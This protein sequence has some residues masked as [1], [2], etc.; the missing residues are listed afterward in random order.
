MSKLGPFERH[1]FPATQPEPQ[2]LVTVHGFTL[3]LPANGP[4][5]ARIDV[6]D[7]EGVRR[8]VEIVAPTGGRNR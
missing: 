5:R 2:T 4:I 1:P 3:D 7:H 8:E 6:E